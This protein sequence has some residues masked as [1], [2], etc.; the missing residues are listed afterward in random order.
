M[1]SDSADE[2]AMTPT[3]VEAPLSDGVAEDPQTSTPLENK[4]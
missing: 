1:P 2:Q 4:L 3:G